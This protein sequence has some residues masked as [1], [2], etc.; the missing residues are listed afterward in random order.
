[1]FVVFI[2]KT[3]WFKYVCIKMWTCKISARFHKL[4]EM[5]PYWNGPDRDVAFPVVRAYWK[6]LCSSCLLYQM[7]RLKLSGILPLQIWRSCFKSEMVLL[8]EVNALSTDFWYLTKQ[9]SFHH[10]QLSRNY[11]HRIYAEVWGWL[12]AYLGGC[13]QAFDLMHIV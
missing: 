11:F 5:F 3:R 4:T 1:M 13:M 9:F 7:L 12:R 2:N 10:W 8:T 6:L